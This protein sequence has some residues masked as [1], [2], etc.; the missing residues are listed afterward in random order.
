MA[1]TRLTQNQRKGRMGILF[2]A[3][4][5]IGFIL[6]FALPIGESLRYSLSQLEM[7]TEGMSMNFIGFDNFQA[8][9][10]QHPSYNRVLTEAVIDMVVNVP[11]I[12][13]FS[14]FSAT[15]LNQKFR[16][17]GLARAIFF[18]PVILA[19]GALLGVEGGDILQNVMQSANSQQGDSMSLL[20]SFELERM[21]IESGANESIVSYLTDAVNRIYEIISR[22]GVQILIFLAGLQSISPSLY[23]AAKIEGA[24]GYEAF[25]KIT[26]PMI[27]PLILTNVIYTVIDA[28]SSS[29]MTVLIQD[30]AFRTFQFGLSSAM[31]WIYFL[32]ISIILFIMYSLISR[33]VFYYD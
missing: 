14:L 6:L 16:G 13:F 11:L 2:L 32:C 4:W 21:L 24:T 15:L 28:F 27:S 30:T 18:L 10:T 7:T 8:A 12:I 25:W 23:E 31:S 26:F 5:L 3:P 33:K 29:Q 17:R 19:S 9:F 1:R 22:S 20:K